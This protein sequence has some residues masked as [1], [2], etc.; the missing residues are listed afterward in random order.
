MKLYFI[1]ILLLALISATDLA[2]PPLL[3]ASKA[4][5]KSLSA[6]LSYIKQHHLISKNDFT[7]NATFY[8]K[9]LRFKQR[10]DISFFYNR[11]GE[12]DF[13]FTPD[14][15]ILTLYSRNFRLHKAARTFLLSAVNNIAYQLVTGFM[16][17]ASQSGS[18]V[19]GYPS[20]FIFSALKRMAE[21]S[22]AIVRYNY[23]LST[24]TNR[25][26][27]LQFKYLLGN[28]LRFGDQDVKIIVSLHPGRVIHIL[29]LLR[30]ETPPKSAPQK[31]N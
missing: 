26:F 20:L 25:V 19:K 8:M 29:K 14:A 2:A 24:Y 1:A 4:I 18:L 11:Q 3:P 31:S 27:S 12:L 23:Q 10:I 28:G 7:L 9:F 6:P 30:E 16:R 15:K 5:P 21:K 22:R 13:E 17:D